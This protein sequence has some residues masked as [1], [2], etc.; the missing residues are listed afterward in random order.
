M[1]LEL[2]D[3]LDVP[4]NR[5]SPGILRKMTLLRELVREPEILVLD[6]PTAFMNAN[7]RFITWKLLKSLN[8]KMT[9]IYSSSSLNIVE[10]FHDR[11]L[12]FHNGGI[13]LDDNIDNMLNNWMGKYQYTIEFEKLLTPFF[14]TI[15]K[16]PGVISTKK[17]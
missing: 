1:H 3:K 5:L 4:V 2:S 16:I 12:V 13:H 7:D 8:G 10:E 6:H 14:R 9:I 15:E 17:D 11:I